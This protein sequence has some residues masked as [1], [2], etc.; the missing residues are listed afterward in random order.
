MAK[1]S[2]TRGNEISQQCEVN[3]ADFYEFAEHPVSEGGSFEL[4]NEEIEPVG[5]HPRASKIASRIGM[6]LGMYLLQNDIGHALTAYGGC[7]I[8][9]NRVQPDELPS[10]HGYV[11]RT[12][13]LAVEVISPNNP[14]VRIMTEVGIQVNAG[15]FVWGVYPDTQQAVVFAPGQPPQVLTE[16]DTLEGGAVLPGF[17]LAVKEI[18]A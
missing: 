12:P 14:E 9:R 16:A 10:E 13:D 7:V 8:G 5:S 15:A 2:V 3:V 6:Y 11:S 18:F 17:T 1:A 4:I